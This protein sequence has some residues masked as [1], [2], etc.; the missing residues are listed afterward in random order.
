MTRREFVQAAVTGVAASRPT[1]RAEA[2][3]FHLVIKGGRVIDPA[4]HVNSM[5]DVGVRDGRI[6]ALEQNISASQA[7]EILDATGKLVTPRAHRHPR[8]H[9]P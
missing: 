9:R 8:A 1:R 5:L 7:D 4:A 6:A 2:A 3:M